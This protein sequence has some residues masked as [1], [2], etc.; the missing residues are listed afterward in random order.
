[1]AVIH[2]RQVGD[3]CYEIR[4]AGR[5]VRLYTNR[6]LHTQYHPERLVTSGVWDLLALPALA[7]PRV[8]RVLLLGVGGGAAIHLLRSW[9]PGV[10]IT[11]VELNPIHLQ[12]ARRYFGLKGSDLT[13]LQADAGHYVRNYRGKPFDLVIEDVFTGS[14]GE[15]DRVFP[16]T[17]P[18]CQALGRLVNKQGALVINTVSTR[19]LRES[20]F[21]R[22]PRIRGQ[23][24]SHLGLTLPCY[25]NAVG[26]FFRLPVTTS[27]LRATVRSDAKRL[28]SERA[29]LLRY[30]IRQK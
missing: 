19:Q 18:W 14:D 23:W 26:A 24:Q 15:P 16:A 6:L 21:V 11:G 17:R 4:T 27:E 5:S 7:L 8:E 10:H 3:T 30:Q 9:C 1:M 20:A 12:L 25:E 13:L 29:G 28:A 22:D 2:S